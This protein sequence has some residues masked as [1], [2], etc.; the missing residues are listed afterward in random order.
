MNKIAVFRALSSVFAGKILSLAKLALI[1]GAVVLFAVIWALAA[2]FDPWWWLLL[3]IAIPV[4]VLG[5][6][7]YAVA[8]MLSR[9]LYPQRLT[10]QQ[11]KSLNNFADKTLRILEARSMPPPLIAAMVV[12]DLLTHRELKSF[13]NLLNDT[14]S[15]RS[16]F[17]KLEEELKYQA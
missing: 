3:I 6:I 7:I 12:K 5:L 4:L 17:A 13:K 14:T 2:F 15:L 11:T 10:K 8:K 9:Q 16:D 1:L